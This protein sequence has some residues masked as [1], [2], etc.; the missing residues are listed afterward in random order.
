[1]R[2]ARATNDL[3]KISKMYAEGLGLQHLGSFEN[4]DGFDGVMI[5]DPSCDYHFEFTHEHGTPA[6]L[7]NSPENLIVF[8]VNDLHEFET[9]SSAML[10]AGFV[11]VKAH[12]PYWNVHGVTYADFENYRVVISSM[13]QQ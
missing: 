7:N 9:R 11:K 12:N 8:Y 3:Q 6:P 2:I 13:R 5:G 1:M 10:A 4:H